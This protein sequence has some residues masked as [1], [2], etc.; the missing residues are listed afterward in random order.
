MTHISEGIQEDSLK[1]LDILL[2]EY[3]TLL[4]DRSSVLLNN[5]VELISHRQLSKQLKNR[6]KISW[7]LSVNPNR[8]VTSQQWRLNVL[9]RLRKFLQVLVEGSSE[10][11]TDSEGLHGQNDSHQVQRNSL[12]VNWQE[13]ANGHQH[14]QLYEN[15]GL[16]PRMNSSFRLRS[17]VSM[18]GSVEKGL[19]SA[20]NLKSFIQIIIPLLLDCWIE[21]SPTQ[22]ADSILENLLEPG[23][24]HIMEQVL[25]IIHLLWKLAKQ[26]EDPHEMEA[27]LRA[28]YLIDFKHHFMCRF[29]Y[30]FEETIK[31]RK[32]DSLK[33][34]K[35]CMTS[36]NK[37]CIDHLLL[38]LTLCEIMVSLASASTLQ[39]D[40]HWLDMIRKFVIE[41]LQ[42]GC[43]LNSKQL[44][45]LLRVAWRLL[46]IQIN[47]VATETLMKAVYTLY[48]QKGLP[49]PVRTLLLNFFS[50]VY[51][52]EE[53]NPH[54]NRSRSKV[55][56]RWLAGLPQQLVLL[57]LKNPELS[58]Q[59][60]GIIYSAASRANKGILQS[61][62]AAAPRI[63]DPLD[64]AVTLLPAE[65]Q[66]RL[67]Q[68]VYFLPHLSSNLLSS[69]S[70]CCITGK[71]SV[72]L[73]TTLIGILRMRSSF[74]GWKYPVQGSSVT[75]MDYFSF[76][77]STLTGFSKE[78]LN[79]LQNIR[80][81]P[82]V[83]QTQLSPVQLY[84]TDLDQFSYHWAVTEVVS[85]C[86]STVPSRSQCIDIVQSGICKYLVG[87][88]VIPDT[89]AGSILCAIS[90][91]LDQACLLNENLSKFLASLCYSLLYLLLTIERED[92]EHLQK[93]DVL[94]GSCISLLTTLPRILRLM[95]QSLQVSRVCREELPVLAQLLRLLMQHGQLRSHMVTNELLVKQI[96]KDIM[97]L[98]SGEPQEQWLTDLHYYFNIYLATHPPGSGAA[99]TVY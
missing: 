4:M 45:K 49:F 72:K 83:S 64:G 22:L 76:L 88:T 62:Q 43:K 5:F 65:S 20:D 33:S 39:M 63:Y 95:L 61:L 8:R 82:H 91:L 23:S 79:N 44:N 55:L 78:E 13:H 71:L 29:P 98:K 57:G 47:K 68:L 66:Q 96:V 41:T 60:I 69:L 85:Q 3:P 87:L 90:K 77:F 11:Q 46:Q 14:I 80:G 16:H 37:Y 86:L 25:C 56:S 21:A 53:L 35:Y 36:S 6:D 58:D 52:K 70:H 84:L 94:W 34:N 7:R 2:E 24:Q 93:R 10:L 18:T 42:D 59:L 67:I 92:T 89:T 19:S 28:N 26:N 32:K 1:V 27:W 75:D 73:S 30:S 38:N 81:R 97:A 15:G 48:Q 31:H 50:N 54:T 74:V 99:N 40:S 12:Q 9:V 17:L 51:Q